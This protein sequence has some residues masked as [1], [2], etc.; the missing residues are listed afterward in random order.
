MTTTTLTN[1]PN[2][3]E[4]EAQSLWRQCRATL[5]AFDIK[6]PEHLTEVVITGAGMIET[7]L[8]ETTE[9]MIAFVNARL[10]EDESASGDL[11]D[12]ACDRVYFLLN[13]FGAS[14]C[15]CRHPARVVHQVESGRRLL[16]EYRNAGDI[17][18]ESALEFAIR[19]RAAE[20]SDHPD[21][22]PAWRPE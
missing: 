22:L 15:S 17:C 19:C 9:A 8:G 3:K 6:L 10:D 16:A 13:G 21:Y 11:H 7:N 1:R 2:F 20:W 18:R 14:A 12:V 5:A 4:W